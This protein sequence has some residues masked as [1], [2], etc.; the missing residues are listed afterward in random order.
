[1]SIE[2]T[3]ENLGVYKIRKLSTGEQVIHV[4]ATLS[5]HY[6]L[7]LGSTGVLSF[8]PIKEEN[9]NLPEVVKTEDIVI[10]S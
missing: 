4:P 9:H 10:G 3:Q 7:F 2:V 5:G 6:I 8:V 1:M